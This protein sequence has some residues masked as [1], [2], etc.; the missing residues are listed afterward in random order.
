[1]QLLKQLK[2]YGARLTSLQLRQQET[3]QTTKR[4]L[5]LRL[6]QQLHHMPCGSYINCENM[7]DLIDTTVIPTADYRSMF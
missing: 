4:D 1:V 3:K 7:V 5:L 6:A 2:S